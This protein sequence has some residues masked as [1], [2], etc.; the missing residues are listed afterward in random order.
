MTHRRLVALLVAAVLLVPLLLAAGTATA[1]GRR[2]DVP[3]SEDYPRLPNPRC[4]TGDQRV[5]QDARVCHL[6]PFRKERPTVVLWGDS[7]AWMLVPALLRQAETDRVNPDVVTLGACPPLMVTA[8]KPGE[9]FG[10]KCER[11]NY[12]ARQYVLKL[13]RAHRPVRVIF[14]ANWVGYRQIY[15]E[16][17]GGTVPTTYEPY[18]VEMANLFHRG[19]PAMFRKMGQI[20]VDV[21]VVGQV[22][23]VPRPAPFCLAGDQPYSCPMLRAQAIPEE[24]ETRDWVHRQMDKL[25]G[26]PRYIDVNGRVCDATTCQARIDGIYTFFDDLHLSATRSR[27]LHFKF[28]RSL[29]FP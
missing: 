21:D 16:S 9:H 20:G 19:T 12:N 8:P 26:T 4:V 13:K 22:L 27:T 17:Q 28:H 6:K 23:T 5:P 11:Q 10:S 18:A 14:A 3:P 29:L 25:A 24:Q 2:A 1:S 15:R 7:H